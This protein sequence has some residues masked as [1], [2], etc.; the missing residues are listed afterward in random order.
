M[1]QAPRWWYPPRPLEKPSEPELPEDSRRLGSLA[2]RLRAV[3]APA[4]AELDW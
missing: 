1:G 3:G 2:A 4:E